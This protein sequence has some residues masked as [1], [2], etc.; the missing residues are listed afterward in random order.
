MIEDGK[1]SRATLRIRSATLTPE[2][3][4]ASLGL[5]ATA[6]HR[7]GDPVSR[8][9]GSPLRKE[10]LFT[11]DSG[12]CDLEPLDHHITV[13]LS[14]IEPVGDRF[15]ALQGCIEADIFCGFSSGHGQGGFALAP[16][17]MGRL[18]A[19]GLELIVDLYPP[20]ASEELD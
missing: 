3:I 17:L 1:W 8:R 14:L 12:V 18:S 7:A 19:L 10:H 20:G 16:E 15:A 11:L 9:Q 4:G 2:E 6:S 13:L 5:R